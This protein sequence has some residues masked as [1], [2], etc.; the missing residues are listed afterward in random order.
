MKRKVA[1]PPSPPQRAADTEGGALLSKELRGAREAHG[2]ARAL[3]PALGAG[4]RA[5]GVTL[6]ADLAMLDEGD[7][8]A[9]PLPPVARRRLAAAA[10]HEL[11]LSARVLRDP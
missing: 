6:R 8:G 5:L 1:Y 7:L 10:Q 2:L 3:W 9:L 11:R 4:L